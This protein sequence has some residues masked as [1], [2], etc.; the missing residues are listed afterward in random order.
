M[1]GKL[2]YLQAVLHEPKQEP[3]PDEVSSVDVQS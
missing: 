1:N 3:N 2:K